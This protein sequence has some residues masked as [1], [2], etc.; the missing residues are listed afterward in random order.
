[1]QENCEYLEGIATRDELL[2]YF[3]AFAY[4][5]DD[6]LAPVPDRACDQGDGGGKALLCCARGGVEV[7]QV[8]ESIACGGQDVQA[9]EQGGR[10][11]AG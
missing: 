3:S 7:V 5:A 6:E 1:M 4:A 8:V 2:S 11:S 10:G 9:I